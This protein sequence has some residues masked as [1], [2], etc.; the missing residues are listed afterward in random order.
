M[1]KDLYDK[2]SLAKE[3]FELADKT[4]GFNLSNIIFTG[5]EEKLTQTP[6]CQPAIL[7]VS[8]VV[9]KIFRAELEKKNFVLKPK[10]A[11][12]HSLG[13]YSSLLAAGVLNFP[14]AVAL[15]HKRGRFMQENSI[16]GGM[17]AVLGLPSE[18]V[19]QIAASIAGV[20]VANYNCPGQVVLSVK[21]ESLERASSE[22]ERQG[23][24]RVVKLQVS[25]PSHSSFM[26]NAAKNLSEELEK[27]EFKE[28]LF[29][30]ISNY[31]AQST[32]EPAILQ[33]NLVQQM[34]HPVRWAESIEE[35]ILQGGDTFLEIGPG[36]VLSGLLKRINPQVQSLRIS[37]TATLGETLEKVASRE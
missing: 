29:P 15:V 7:T 23:A 26:E 36:K 30:V 6:I 28:P 12:G 24:K 11:L 22:V 2:Y 1:G 35:A 13:E 34:I 21:R 4:L 31:S 25:I 10:V 33:E 16:Q 20:E 19:E 14:E 27:I 32:N 18:K 17:L 37:D 9:F 8:Y 3:I 5:P